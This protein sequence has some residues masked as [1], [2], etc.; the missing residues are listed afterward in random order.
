MWKEALREPH[1]ILPTTSF[2]LVNWHISLGLHDSELQQTS[3]APMCQAT[4]SSHTHMC[5]G[6]HHTYTQIVVG[7]SGRLRPV[8]STS[9]QILYLTDSRSLHDSE[10][11][12]SWA[13]KNSPLKSSL[14]SAW[15]TPRTSWNQI[16]KH[17]CGFHPF[18]VQKG[19]SS[20]HLHRIWV[21]IFQTGSHSLI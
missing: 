5:A 2:G 10:V 15:F 13:A 1:V 3:L 4:L 19:P 8:H 21:Q 20:Y 7:E 16:N 9:G 6:T 14:I 12:T 11:S 18:K 17:C